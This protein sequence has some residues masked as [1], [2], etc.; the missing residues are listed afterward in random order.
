MKLVF[1]ETYSAVQWDGTLGSAEEVAAFLGEDVSVL[2]SV[3]RNHTLEANSLDFTMAPGDVLYYN[4]AE[5]NYNIVD[6]SLL[7]EDENIKIV[8]DNGEESK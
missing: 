4:H 2:V 8:N 1:T 7:E 6:R 3:S 5:V